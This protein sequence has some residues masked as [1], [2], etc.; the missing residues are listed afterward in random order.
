MGPDTRP[1][2]WTESVRRPTPRNRPGVPRIPPP[3]SRGP[4]PGR[5]GEVL[6]AVLRRPEV[7]VALLLLVLVGPLVQD[8]TAQPAPRV[9]LTGALVD[10]GTL[11]LDGYPLGVDHAERDG[12]VY[13]DKAPGQPLLAV[14][15][16]ALA[17]AVGAEPAAVPRWQGNLT[18]WWLTVVSALLPL[19]AVVAMAAAALR[20]RGIEPTVAVLGSLAFGTLLLPFGAN[21]Y[22][23]VLAGALLYAGWLV[24]DGA[25]RPAGRAWVAGALLG[26]A[27]VTE[28]QAA[29]VVAVVVGWVALERRWSQLLRLALG[30]APLAAG[31]LVHQVA[32]T[33]SPLGTGYDA[34]PGTEHGLVASHMQRPSPG[35]ALEVLLGSKGV[36]LF[37]P[38]VG[39]A[40]WGL[41]RRWW[42]H[43]DP[44]G[45]VGLAALGALL[46]LQSSW[47]HAGGGTWAGEMPGPRFLVPA[48]P[49]LAV[50]LAEAWPAT[51]PAVRRALAAVSVLSMA[52]PTLT[53]HLVPED[54]VLVGWS[55]RALLED[56]PVPTLFTLAVGPWGW[57]VHGALA[58]LVVAAVARAARPAPPPVTVP[59]RLATVGG[60]G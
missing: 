24:L 21:L 2:V 19:V 18:Q 20:R 27:V 39:L 5:W 41:V 10:D 1:A 55:G 29:L 17:R 50:G 42:R 35:Q 28:Y 6:L 40:A 47:S 23:H 58:G 48:L 11:R 14:P 34:K 51:R 30:A 15:A 59:A 4:V 38:V 25:G 31:L 36:L 13:S 60:G 8:L 16:Y 7:V 45:P 43:R 33:G 56:G 22:G 57:L 54:A 53:L 26:A 32:V 49:F 12:H 3:A 52:L 37:T 44:A 9:A 46:V